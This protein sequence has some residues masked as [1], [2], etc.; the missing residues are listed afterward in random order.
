MLRVTLDRDD[1]EHLMTGGTLELSP[2]V[3]I[4]L[5]DMGR[6][7]VH[8]AF[9]AACERIRTLGSLVGVVRKVNDVT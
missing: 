2:D 7:T 3:Q 4:A 8:K 5:A 1:L 6:F 9:E